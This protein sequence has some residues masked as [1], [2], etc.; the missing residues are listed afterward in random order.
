MSTEVLWIVLPLAI[1]TL[2]SLSRTLELLQSAENAFNNDRHEEALSLIEE[3]R[4]EL[5]KSRS[6]HST[7]N[8]LKSQARSFFIKNWPIILITFLFLSGLGIFTKKKISLSLL[9][10][11]IK[12]LKAEKTT[13]LNL[14]KHIQTQRYKDNKISGLVYNIRSKKYQ[15]RLNKIK[16]ELPVLEK[17]LPPKKKN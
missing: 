13:L 9:K 15:D 11:K 16:Q 12:K 2:T 8:T 17:Q 14:I 7:L 3:T 4:I 10:K 1:A 5:E 6:E